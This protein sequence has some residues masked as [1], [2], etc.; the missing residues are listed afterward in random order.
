VEAQTWREFDRTLLLEAEGFSSRFVLEE[1]ELLLEDQ[2][3]ELP[4]PQHYVLR[5]GSGIVRFQAG[6]MLQDLKGSPLR[7][8]RYSFTPRVDL[9]DEEEALGVAPRFGSSMELQVGADPRPQQDFLSILWWTIL[10]GSFGMIMVVG[11]V[12]WVGVR[13]G[14]KPLSQFRNRIQALDEHQLAW[15][16]SEKPV[17]AEILP[18]DQELASLISRLQQT[19]ERERRFIDAAAHE[20]RTPLSELRTVSEVSLQLDHPPAAEKA[21]E[22]CR[23][24][25]LEMEGMVELLLQLSRAPQ[26]FASSPDDMLLQTVLL[27]Q[28]GALEKEIKDKDLAVEVHLSPGCPWRIPSCAAQLLA[29]NLIENAVCYTPPGG[30]IGISWSQKKAGGKLLLQNGPVTIPENELAHLAEPFWRGDTARADRR[31]H[32]LGLTL[33]DTVARACH[34]H[35]SFQIQEERLVVTLRDVI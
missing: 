29:R 19:L 12:T 21:I 20:L 14:L 8:I 4:L 9:S 10:A 23:E 34:L 7:S 17:P 5:D 31:H 13:R 35:L 26:E 2:E 30:S 3:L 1:G 6:G 32:G 28:V 15:K 24:I 11:G 25:G 16:P 18:I 33:V 27:E 22:Q